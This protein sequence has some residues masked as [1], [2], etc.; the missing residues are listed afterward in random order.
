MR[1]FHPL[2]LAVLVFLAAATR[3][4]AQE[5]DTDW[6]L[7]G[8]HTGFCIQL[9]V[10][11]AS[12]AVRS[13]P[14]GFRALPA[15][16]AKDLHTSLRDVIASQSEFASWSPSRLCFQAV[17]TIRSSE[18]LVK[19]KRDRPQLFGFWT[20]R[21]ASSAGEAKDVVL[22][23]YTSSG[24]L[25]RAAEKIGPEVRE[26]RLRM[27]KVPIVDED[28]VP[29]PD[30]R[31]EVKLGKTLITWDG[32]LASDTVRLKQPVVS[33]WAVKAGD[34]GMTLSAEVARSMVGALKV[35]GKDDFA[36]ALK[37]S[38]TRFAGPAYQ[39]GSGV[40]RLGR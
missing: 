30:D 8:L 21:A 29:S 35:E 39:G 11:P 32:R 33:E 2:G 17:D 22:A 36:Q 37:A 12:E 5:T 27:G 20:M 31:F 9:L 24:R 23:L 38:P 6:H 18:F 25:A 10:N 34:G 13:L 28:G 7:E 1:P 3:L 15:S 19:G 26:G 4:P 40:V 14:S 16:E